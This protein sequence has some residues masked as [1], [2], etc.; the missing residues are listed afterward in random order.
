MY[1]VEI[2]EKIIK[3]Y[4]VLVKKKINKIGSLV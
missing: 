1:K 3:D 4:V 2:G